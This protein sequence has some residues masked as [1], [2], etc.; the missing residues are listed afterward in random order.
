MLRKFLSQSL[1]IF[2][3][4]IIKIVNL[5]NRLIIEKM[6]NN[7][8]VLFNIQYVQRYTLIEVL[9]ANFLKYKGYKVK[10]LVCAGHN[11]CEIYSSNNE[12]PNCQMCRAKSF[13]ILKAGKIEF[14]DLKAYKKS[15]TNKSDHSV[16]FNLSELKNY[17]DLETNF[18]IGETTYWNWLHYSNG[19]I[20]PQNTKK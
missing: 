10:G 14:V 13:S 19:A 8:T 1:L 4:Q 2:N 6:V 12:K 20:I 15:I 7:E 11:Y 17:N 16:N 5:L 18:P 3:L 9:F